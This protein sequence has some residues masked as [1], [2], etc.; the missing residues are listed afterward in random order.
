MDYAVNYPKISL[1]AARVNAN[2]SQEEAARRIGVCKSTL[3]SYEKGQT[4][5]AWDTVDE[6][7]RVYNFPA[8][9]ICFNQKLALNE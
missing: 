6:I 5:P 3:Q 8:S 9:L 7:A 2:L 4:V 1:K